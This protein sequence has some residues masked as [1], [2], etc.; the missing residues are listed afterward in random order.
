MARKTVLPKNWL[1]VVDVGHLIRRFLGKC[2]VI[3]ACR[4]E[5]GRYR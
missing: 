3:S 1:H 5:R 2:E 4:N